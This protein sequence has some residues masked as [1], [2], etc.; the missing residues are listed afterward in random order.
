MS[1][2]SNQIGNTSKPFEKFI[3]PL[4]KSL[5]DDSQ[6]NKI[7]LENLRKKQLNEAFAIKE[8]TKK[9]PKILDKIN[10]IIKE[11]HS[12]FNPFQI[13]QTKPNSFITNEQFNDDQRRNI[14]PKT[15][16]F[17]Y[18]SNLFPEISNNL[19]SFFQLS[20]PNNANIANLELMLSNLKNKSLEPN[21]LN[22][23]GN[24]DSAFTILHFLGTIQ[25]EISSYLYNLGMKSNLKNES[26]FEKIH[27]F[28]MNLGNSNI[29]NPFLFPHLHVN[30]NSNIF[31]NFS[32]QNNLN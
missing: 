23:Q 8:I 1:H 13:P 24:K 17:D 27:N 15:Q 28:F 7:L 31:S 19:P 25:S 9:D 22:N 5:E 12:N 10:T 30:N 20:Q 6:V 26:K 29:L 14:P 18:Y 21:F 4:K 16:N 32:Q 2:Q 3:H 11:T